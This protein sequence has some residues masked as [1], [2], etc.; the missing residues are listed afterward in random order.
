MASDSNLSDGQ[1]SSLNAWVTWKETL[2]SEK[3]EG[4]CLTAKVFKV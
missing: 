4:Q 2:D 1:N 3:A